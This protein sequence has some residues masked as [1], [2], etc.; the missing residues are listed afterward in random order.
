MLLRKDRR[1]RVPPLALH[2]L[3]SSEHQ[4]SDK[5]AKT[6]RFPRFFALFTHPAQHP[7]DGGFGAPVQ[8]S[9]APICAASL[10]LSCWIRYPGRRTAKAFE[11]AVRISI[12]AENITLQV[13]VKR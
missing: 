13:I 7:S 5:T 4:K 8:V 12:P 9:S 10:G 2:P 11:R 3:D 6:R 1:V